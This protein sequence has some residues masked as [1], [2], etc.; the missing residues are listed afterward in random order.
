[1]AEQEAEMQRDKLFND[2]RPMVPTKQVRMPKQIQGAVV[3]TSV[4][5]APTPPKE[6]DATAVTSSATPIDSTSL[7]QISE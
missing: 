6:D 2:I 7:G 3:S 4:T 1:M 5:A